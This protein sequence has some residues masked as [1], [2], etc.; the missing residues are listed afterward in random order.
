MTQSFHQRGTGYHDQLCRHLLRLAD[1][2][3]QQLTISCA[4]TLLR[5]AAGH[6]LCQFASDDISLT[7]AMVVRDIHAELPTQA[8]P[9]EEEI[10]CLAIQIQTRLTAD[11]P[12]SARPWPPRASNWFTSADLH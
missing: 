9:G 2:S 7:L 3:L 11:P 5:Q 8:P 12:S 4:I 6:E 10:A 1:E